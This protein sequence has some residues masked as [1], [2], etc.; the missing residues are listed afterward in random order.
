MTRVRLLRQLPV[1]RLLGLPLISL[2]YGVPRPLS[3]PLIA[4][5]HGPVRPPS[6]PPIPSPLRQLMSF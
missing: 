1:T 4:L 5:P 2:P 3:L 6:P